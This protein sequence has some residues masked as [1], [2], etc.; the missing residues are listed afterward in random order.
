MLSETTCFIAY[1]VEILEKLPIERTVLVIFVLT[2]L[3]V[4]IRNDREEKD[5]RPKV[6][7]DVTRA[8]TRKQCWQ[9]ALLC[10]LLTALLLVVI[11][12]LNTELEWILRMEQSHSET[13]SRQ[14][15]HVVSG[16]GSV[17]PIVLTKNSRDW[18]VDDHGLLILDKNAR[19]RDSNLFDSSTIGNS[20]CAVTNNSPLQSP[21]WCPLRSFRFRRWRKG[22]RSGWSSAT[23]SPSWCQSTGASRPY[24]PLPGRY[25]RHPRLLQVLKLKK[26]LWLNLVIQSW[27]QAERRVYRHHLQKIRKC[28]KIS[29]QVQMAA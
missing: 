2:T 24:H 13:E 20:K 22:W 10:A 18:F 16:T 19:L 25:P 27:T 9:R 14:G 8:L 12:K 6:F 28:G 23:I 1:P 4:K 3:W 29:F 17:R 15:S 11:G 21:R 7:F 5:T 26:S